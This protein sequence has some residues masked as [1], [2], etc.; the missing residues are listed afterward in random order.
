MR[1]KTKKPECPL[2]PPD[3][4]ERIRSLMAQTNDEG[5]AFTSGQRAG[6]T[7]SMCFLPCQEDTSSTDKPQVTSNTLSRSFDDLDIPYIDEDE[8][9][10]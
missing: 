2:K 1:L 3:L 9:L 5:R 7:Q 8:D 6:V 4:A 10:T